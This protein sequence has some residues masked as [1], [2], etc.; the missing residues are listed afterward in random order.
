MKKL[1]TFN[2]SAA[3]KRD[4][5]YIYN[6]VTFTRMFVSFTA[7]IKQDMISMILLLVAEWKDLAMALKHANTDTFTSGASSL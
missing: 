2:R 6:A 3:S 4:A 5:T 1:K 7:S